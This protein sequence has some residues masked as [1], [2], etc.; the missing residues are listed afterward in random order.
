MKKLNDED[1]E[2]IGWLFQD[3][4][5]KHRQLAKCE[6]AAGVITDWELKENQSTADYYEE[7]WDCLAEILNKH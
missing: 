7:L 3:V 1:K 6:H 4:I 2:N 5:I